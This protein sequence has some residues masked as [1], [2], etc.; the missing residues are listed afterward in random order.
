MV[1]I[2]NAISQEVVTHTF[3]KLKDKHI[4]SSNETTYNNENFY[5]WGGEGMG[6]GWVLGVRGGGRRRG[7]GGMKTSLN[8]T[9]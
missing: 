8:K 5:R 3:T 7:G 2:Q 6:R 9:I 4:H 1:K